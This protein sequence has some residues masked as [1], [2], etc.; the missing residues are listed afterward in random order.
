MLRSQENENNALTKNNNTNLNFLKEDMNNNTELL[1]QVSNPTL[2]SI[3]LLLNSIKEVQSVNEVPPILPLIN[4]S[5]V[6]PMKEDQFEEKNNNTKFLNEKLPPI[7]KDL[8][9]EKKKLPSINF[10]FNNINNKE[11]QNRKRKREQESN[12][13]DNLKKFKL[14]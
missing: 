7:Q 6:N 13:N 9:K 10:L 14:F 4:L 1:T 2:P 8:K 5:L 12:P 3:K 11:D